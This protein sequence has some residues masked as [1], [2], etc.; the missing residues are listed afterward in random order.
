MVDEPIFV[1]AS[2]FDGGIATTGWTLAYNYQRLELTDQ[3]IRSYNFL[4]RLT[5]SADYAEITGVKVNG[6]ENGGAYIQVGD[7]SVNVGS[8][9]DLKHLFSLLHEA[10]PDLQ[11]P[12]E[13]YW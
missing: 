8:L 3:G 11:I 4:G 10:R 5:L 6:G 13:L 1:L 9:S 7:R 12:R 2:F